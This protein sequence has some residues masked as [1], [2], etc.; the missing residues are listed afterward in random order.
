M[1]FNSALSGIR[2]AN[3]DL[4]VTGNNIANASTVGFKASRAEFGDVYAT[5]L[6]GS[7]ATTIGSG[8]QLQSVSQQFGQG[9][10]NFTEN[11]LDLSISGGGFFIVSQGGDQL[12]TRAGTLGLDSEGNIVTNTN[13]ILQGFAADDNGNVGGVLGNLQILANTQPP[14][15][16]TNVSS[17]LNLDSNEPVLQ[18]TG[19]TFATDGSVIGVVQTGQ[20]TATTTTMDIGAVAVPIDFG[21]SP[22]TFDITLT[23]TTPASANGTVSVNINSSVA[24]SVQDVANLINN[25]IFGD[26]S[27]INVQAIANGSNLEFQDLSTGIGSTISLANITGANALS[28]GLT[29]A[30]AST[31]GVAATTNGYATQ[32]L[33]IVNPA[34]AIINYNS[35]LG[36]SAAQTASE[37]N[38]LAGVTATA[39]TN[40]S[41][42]SGTFDNSNSNLVLNGVALTSTTI[43]GLA[44]E[45]NTLSGSTLP[46]ISATI[47]ASTGDLDIASVVGD[48]LNFSF[49][50]TGAGQVDLIGRVGT[51]G[52]SVSNTPANQSGVIGGDITIVLQENYTIASSTPTVGNLFA[53]FTASTFEPVVINEFNPSDPAT[54]NHATSVTTYDSL[55]NSHV[56]TQFFVRQEYDVNDP[57]TSPNHW[58]MFVQIDGQDVGDP[59][60]ALAP[61]ENT[62]PTRL[63]FDIH[64]NE[65]GSLNTLLT[66]PMLVSNWTPLDASG[67]PNGSLGAQNVLQGGAIP[68]PVP[69]TSSNF[70]IDMNGSTQ[71]G[72]VFAVNAVDQNG[73]TT[74]RLSGLDVDDSGVIFA[75]YTNG[76]A[77][78]LG[79]IALAD[80]RNVQ[81][82]QPSGNTMWAETFETGEPN[83]GTPGSASLGAINSGALEE[84]NVDLS[85]QLV[86]LII[87]QRNFQA[88]AKTIE[89]ANQTTQTIINI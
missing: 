73:Y 1:P 63:S 88:S 28:T 30:G 38:A 29:G 54:Y 3:N 61:P 27:P 87:A 69:A 41:I 13:A 16:T 72:S 83:I 65:D 52:Q 78:T 48:D 14:S 45:I 8:V 23:G 80:F 86:N 35:Q 43:A 5:T 53:P 2:A 9:N 40:G 42:D 10:L 7:G 71:F 49:S 85:Q 11:E 32:A 12:Y 79:Q 37:L 33:E 21:A 22:T 89:T 82:L 26:P 81:G 31:L 18:S 51:G 25:A 84:S 57:T 15:Q 4:R 59:N 19:S 74:G 56:M 46:G 55:G 60:T 47:N 62:L 66:P 24:N 67:N 6:S 70:E 36:A 76:E 68:I 58:N 17:E 34:G 64:F 75:R 39:S 20:A 44:D 50:G 77:Q